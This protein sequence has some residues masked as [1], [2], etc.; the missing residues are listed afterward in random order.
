MTIHS[1]LG[2]QLSHVTASS[3]I[4]Y[5]SS[6]QLNADSAIY[7]WWVPADGSL[8]NP[9]INNPVATPT[10]TTVYTVYGMDI[11]GCVDSAFVTVHVDS[12]MHECIPTGFTPNGDG[13][14]DI[15]R[16][17][18]IKFQNLVDFRVYNRWGQQVFYT[19]NPEIGW[20]GTFNGVVQD[21][22]TYFYT[23]IVGRPGG[24][25]DN[26]IYKGDVTLIK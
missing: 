12:D 1:V 21:M 6:I 20:D 2:K 26:I 24:K 23:I 25:G 22:G 11:Y 10:E 14:N 17:V 9:N 8:N 3:T 16:P 4:L 18:G 19:A 7:Y 5:G 15:F 13:L